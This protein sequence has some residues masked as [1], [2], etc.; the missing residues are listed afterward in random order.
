MVRLVGRAWR[1]GFD[2]VAALVTAIVVS[3]TLKPRSTTGG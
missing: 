1:Q 3:S 2:A